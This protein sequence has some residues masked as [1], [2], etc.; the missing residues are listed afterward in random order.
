[1][2]HPG[3]WKES[4]FGEIQKR[5]KRYGIIDLQ[6]LIELSGF[7]GRGELQRAHRQWVEQGLEN[8]LAVRDDHWSEVIAV[9]SLAFVES[10]KSQLG[11][12]AAHR[13]VIEADGSYALRE[14]TGAYGLKF[15]AENEALS[16]KNT[17]FWN[18]SVDELTT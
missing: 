12:K 7:A 6:S 14:T 9:G 15:T 3:E 4:G 1:V 17:I 13:D 2:N 18:E 11:V 10:V 5:P 8:G 16:T